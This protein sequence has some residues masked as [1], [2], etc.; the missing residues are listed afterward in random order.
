[1][2]RG[3]FKSDVRS[4]TGISI[5]YNRT[6]KRYRNVY[7]P[8]MAR[9]GRQLPGD[10][11]DFDGPAPVCPRGPPTVFND[12]SLVSMEFRNKARGAVS[13]FMLGCEIVPLTSKCS[14]V[15]HELLS[16]RERYIGFRPHLRDASAQP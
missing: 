2:S 14:E 3:S 8:R 16:R 7:C 4:F 6:L 5:T 11:A 10:A 13:Q 9:Q 12:S 1:M 15:D